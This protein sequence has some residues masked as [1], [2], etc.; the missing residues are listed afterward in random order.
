MSKY[1]KL[2]EELEKKTDEYAELLQDTYN[3]REYIDGLYGDLVA[4]SKEVLES[5]DEIYLDPDEE[6]LF[7]EQITALKNAIKLVEEEEK[8]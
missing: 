7:I 6:W 4:A 1:R 3:E 5:L 8:E 2:I